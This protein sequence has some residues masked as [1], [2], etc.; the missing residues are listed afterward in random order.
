MMCANIRGSKLWRQP[1]IDTKH[2]L[3]WACESPGNKLQRDM[4][5]YENYDLYTLTLVQ[6]T[7]IFSGS[8]FVLFRALCAI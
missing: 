2:K 3:G 6:V 4:Y 5:L 8:A 7:S 1:E